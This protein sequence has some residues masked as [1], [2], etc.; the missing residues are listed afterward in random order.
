MATPGAVLEVHAGEVLAVQALPP[1]R[2]LRRVP[3]IVL[4]VEEERA[5]HPGD[6]FPE[7]GGLEALLPER[8]KLLRMRSRR[9]RLSQ[10]T[11]RRAQVE[12]DKDESAIGARV[13]KARRR[14]F[15]HGVLATSHDAQMRH[16]DSA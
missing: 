4:L 2:W 8:G 7:H 3:M 11:R 6:R 16:M 10:E 15:S 14:L 1:R 13:N 5:D 9:G 12:A